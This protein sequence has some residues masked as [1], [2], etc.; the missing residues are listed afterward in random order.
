MSRAIIAAVF[1]VTGGVLV[2]PALS[3][4]ETLRGVCVTAVLVVCFAVPYL[5]ALVTGRLVEYLRGRRDA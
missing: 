5:V 3:D 2:F 1:F 4:P